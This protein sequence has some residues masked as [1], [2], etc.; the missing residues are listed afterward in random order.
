[1][2]IKLG[3]KRGGIVIVSDI[4]HPSISKHNWHQDKRRLCQR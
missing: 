1:M 2:E 4:D 3:G